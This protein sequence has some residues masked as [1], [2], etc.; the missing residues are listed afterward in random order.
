MSL[1][2]PLA[3]ELEAKAKALVARLRP[4]AEEDVLAL[5]R[6]LVSLAGAWSDS[7][8]EAAQRVLPEMAGLQIAETTVQRTTE[9]VGAR[10]AA[11]RRRGRTCGFARAWDWYRDACGRTCAYIS[12]D[13]TGVR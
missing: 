10:I 12:L 5:A 11:Q 7:F 13:L 1:Q 3:P 8:A 6:R 9:G 4:Q 2:Q